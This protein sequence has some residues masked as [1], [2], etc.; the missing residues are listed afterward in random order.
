LHHGGKLKE[1]DMIVNQNGDEV[2]ET[3]LFS[4]SYEIATNYERDEAIRLILQHLKCT[5]VRT[6]ATKHGNTELELRKDE[7]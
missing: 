7:S 4:Y 3:Y 1:N 6:N 2:V 5:I